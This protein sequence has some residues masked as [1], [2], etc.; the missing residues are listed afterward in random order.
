M[1]CGSSERL[2]IDHTHTTGIMRGLL[3]YKHNT[4]LG[5]FNDNAVLLRKAADYLD[6]F[7]QNTPDEALLTEP[8]GNSLDEDI[9]ILL[10]DP[11]FTSDR[12]RARELMR[13][14]PLSYAAAQTRMCRA[15]KVRRRAEMAQNQ[16]T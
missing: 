3:C 4:G 12:S 11:S 16:C 9:H 7:C 2:V 14:Q 5:M 15:R 1:I 13:R 8:V 6:K 10:D